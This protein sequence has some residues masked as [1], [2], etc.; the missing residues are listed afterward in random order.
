M[1]STIYFKAFI[2][3]FLDLY[4]L[5]FDLESKAIEDIDLNNNNINYII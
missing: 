4:T 1:I 5:I 3:A 2:S